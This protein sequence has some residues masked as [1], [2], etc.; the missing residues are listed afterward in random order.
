MS[1]ARLKDVTK[2]FGKVRAVDR[3]NLEIGKGECFSVR[4]PSGYG[5]TS[6]LRM[7]ADFECLDDGEIYV[8]DRLLSS[9]KKGAT[10]PQKSAISGWCF[11][12]SQSVSI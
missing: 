4:S 12:H 7:V 3:L 10:F 6:T 8:G 11:R 2:E 5:K 1:Y 9:R